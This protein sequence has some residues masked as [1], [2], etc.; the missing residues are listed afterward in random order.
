MI[1]GTL[2]QKDTSLLVERV[3]E[4]SE[5][6]FAQRA[7]HY[8]RTMRF[9]EENFKDLHREGLLGAVIS[10]QYGGYELGHH[11][12]EV[13]SLWMMTKEIAKADMAFAR[14]WEGHNNAMTLLNNIANN[15][16]KSR[17]FEGVVER[18]EIWSAWSGEPQSPSTGEKRRFGTTISETE[19]GYLINGSKVFCTGS[20]GADWSILMVNKEAPGGARHSSSNDQSLLMLACDLSDPSVSFDDSWWDPIGMKGSVSY[21]VNFKDTFIPKEN[22]IGYSGQFLLEEWQTRFIPQ[23]AATFLGGAE[24]AYKYTLDYI[25][26]QEKGQDPYIQHRIAK[27]AMNIE[28][29]NLWLKKTANLWSKDQFDEAKLA[30]NQ[31]RYLVEQ[32]AMDTLTHAIHACGA[33][34]LIRPSSLERIYRDLS[35]Y[36]RHDNDDQVLAVIGKSILGFNHDRSFFKQDKFKN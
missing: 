32:L 11:D 4:L 33:R 27:M 6:K 14:C 10:D 26:K 19:N 22:L 1:N 16:Q 8:D 15:E 20:T 9:P 18:G 36:V 31:T 3:R 2:I 23:Y 28:T 25:N 24:A 21:L 29:A 12:G 35:F 17:W 13:F 7:D 5:S 34:S 30:G